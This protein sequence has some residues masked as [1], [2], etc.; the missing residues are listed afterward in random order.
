MDYLHVGVF[1]PFPGTEIY[2]EALE[3]GVYEND[4]WQD[5]ARN[6]TTDF[7]PN[8]W[9]QYFSNEQLFYLLNR[10]Y[11]QFYSR[12]SYLTRRLLKLRS[13]SDFTRKAK[14]GF[15]LLKSVHSHRPK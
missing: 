7:T 12:P 2:T 11:A 1:T 14:L 6:P 9:N 4:Y 13:F 5:F 10:I 15:K 8:Y 3:N